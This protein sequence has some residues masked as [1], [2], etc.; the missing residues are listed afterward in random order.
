MPTFYLKISILR[1]ISLSQFFFF[2]K[3]LKYMKVT[4]KLTALTV[5][6]KIPTIQNLYFN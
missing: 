1:D 3:P 4:R 5:N 2:F 6:V